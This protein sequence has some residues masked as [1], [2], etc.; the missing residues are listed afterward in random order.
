MGKR[1]AEEMRELL[2]EDTLLRWHLQSNHYPP[3]PLYMVE[4]A[5]EAMVAAREG[6]LERELKLPEGVV[7]RKSGARVTARVV[8]DHMH[9]WEF[10][11]RDDDVDS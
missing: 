5:K 6:D 1:Q 7:H 11:E 9:L 8:M 2:Q 3:I 10:V 4:T